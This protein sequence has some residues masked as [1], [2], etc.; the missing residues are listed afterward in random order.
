ML[1][2]FIDKERID[3]IG[4]H[5]WA[6]QVSAGMFFVSIGLYLATMFAY[7]RLLMPKRFWGEKPPPK[8]PQQRPTWLVWRPPSS[9]VWV[10]Y[11]NMMRIWRYLFTAATYAVLLGIFFLAVAVFKLTNQLIILLIPV[12][13][14]MVFEYLIRTFPKLGSED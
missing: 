6:L 8:E 13:G 4:N 3:Y 1:G 2:S 11:Q 14:I 9:A 5:L 7:D 10:L 12:V